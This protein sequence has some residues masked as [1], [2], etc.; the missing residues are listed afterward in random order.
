MVNVGKY[1]SPM[2]SLGSKLFIDCSIDMYKFLG[3]VVEQCDKTSPEKA[4]RR[5]MF[6]SD[7][8]FFAFL[9]CCVC[10][11]FKN[12]EYSFE[13]HNDCKRKTKTQFQEKQAHIILPCLKTSGFLAGK[14]S[15]LF[16]VWVE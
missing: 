15:S 3:F 16:S 9:S 11:L 2:D 14:W 7:L 13:L 4:A 10:F 6:S 5:T 8:C 1:T 12:C